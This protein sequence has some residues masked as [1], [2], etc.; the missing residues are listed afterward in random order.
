MLTFIEPVFLVLELYVFIGMIKNF[1]RWLT[2]LANVRDEESQD[3]SNWE[4]PLTRGSLTVRAFVILLTL[5]SYI[6]IYFIIQESKSLLSFS[7]QEQEIPLTFNHAIAVLVTLQ[8][9]ALSLTIYKEDGILSE[10]AMI[11]LL[12]S[13]PIFV[14][15][16]SYY[17]AK[18]THLSLR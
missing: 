4:P 11:A 18:Q 5:L 1:N 8:L 16:L 17:H 9:I 2:K 12:A 15:S 14:A 13:V 7:S 3:L 6:G 10:S